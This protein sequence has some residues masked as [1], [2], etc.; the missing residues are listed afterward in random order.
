MT[1]KRVFF[2]ECRR[3]KGTQKA[4]ANEIG[5]SEV[6]L[7]MIE[8]GTFTPG[9]DLMFKLCEY[10][11]EPIINLFPDLYQNLKSRVIR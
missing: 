5:I 10:F 6:Y 11:N 8:N 1:K 9:R 7:R 4:V 2:A 3:K